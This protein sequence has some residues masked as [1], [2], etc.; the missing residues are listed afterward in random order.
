MPNVED[1]LEK[2]KGF[3][4]RLAEVRRLV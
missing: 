2:N 1:L 4:K 3:A